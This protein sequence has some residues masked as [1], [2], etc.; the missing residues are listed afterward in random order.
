MASEA[1][2]PVQAA[3]AERERGNALYKAGNLTEAESAYNQA[4]RLAPTDPR[5][6]SN[7]TAVKFEMGNYIGAAIFCEKVLKL[8]QNAPD[9][10]LE[11]KVRVR[12]GKSYMLARRPAQAA[13]AVGTLPEASEGKQ[14]VEQSIQAMEASD[15]LF[16]EPAK[17]RREMME[18]LSRFK[19]VVQDEPEYYSV[20]HD[21]PEPEFNLEMANSKQ[22]DYSFLFAGV[23]DARNLFAT[24]ITIGSMAT[25]NPALSSN[26]F[27][28]TLLDIKPS[29]FARDLLIFRLLLDTKHKSK[30]KASETLA[31]ISYLFTASTMPAWAYSRAQTAIT[32]LLRELGTHDATIMT[33]FYVSNADREAISVHLR[34]WQKEPEGWYS[35]SE[36]LNRIQGELLNTKTKR[37][38]GQGNEPDNGAPPG[39]QS[40]SPDVLEY[41]DLGVMLPPTNLLKEHEERLVELLKEYRKKRTP[42]NK[43]KL[44]HYFQEQWKP[45]VTLVDLE[46]E[47]KRAHFPKPSLDF[48]PHQTASLLWGNLPPGTLGKKVS[49]VMPHLEGFFDCVAKALDRILDQ[50]A[51]EVVLGDMVDYFESAEN[52][53]LRSEAHSKSVF[54][55]T[56]P[57][58]FDRIHMSNIP[59]YVGGAMTTF[60]HAL[61]I[62]RP[63][64]TSA[65]TSN[66]LRNTRVWPTHDSFLVDSLLLAG[67]SK[68]ENTFS[69]SLVPECAQMEKALESMGA[70]MVFSMK[71]MRQS[72]KALE[73]SKLMPRRNL[74]HWL[75]ALFF[76]LC[77]PFPW[78]SDFD[79]RVLRPLNLTTMFR[80]IVHLAKVGYPAY[81]LSGILN[82]LA[83]GEVSSTARPPRAPVTDAAEAKK[84]HSAKLI[85]MKPFVT[86][87]RML[88][89]L[90]QR[91]LPFGLLLQETVEKQLPD[92]SKV[93]QFK[94]KFAD[95]NEAFFDA[96]ARDPNPLDVGTMSS[97]LVFW[98]RTVNGEVPAEGNLRQAL[99]DDESVKSKSFL[100]SKLQK[101]GRPESEDTVHVVST[102][103]WKRGE[104]MA[105]FWFPGEII[106]AM[107]SGPDDWVA[108]IWSTG[109]W[110]QTAS[111][112]VVPEAIV[113]GDA[114]C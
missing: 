110:T 29:V 93:R 108:C 46:W 82:D 107:V 52:G 2:D 72:T 16:S 27:H 21:D 105:S 84:M 24:L 4:V 37:M 32:D 6:L 85:S 19:F 44:D 26:K 50:S 111:V 47:T 67:R 94:V 75:H 57:D 100:K 10:D 64:K 62:L 8:L 61:P 70:V 56:F 33:K 66:V 58:K 103:Q 53:L 60:M 74:E 77:L 113:G 48:T 28:F 81:W 55:T 36:I 95:I 15:K 42:G 40:G 17:L 13:K 96:V 9:P 102:A 3:L 69:A 76:R 5:P 7:A 92:P 73:W 112:S 45:N 14:Q 65:V 87:Y 114:W 88:L 11:E 109:S 106:E 41:E 1:S 91:L 101:A 90:W 86:E 49:G 20:G 59:D 22:D 31:V 25:S 79:S 51:F 104:S 83:N 99:L 68:I 78:V 38:L 18:R 35:T 30:I 12:M 89:S 43:R 98:N 54:P 34:N 63:K 23:G 80:L 71:W 97:V 39:C